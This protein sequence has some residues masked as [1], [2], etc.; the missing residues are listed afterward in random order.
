V[1]GAIWTR[2]PTLIFHLSRPKALVHQIDP[3]AM[4]EGPSH[5]GVRKLRLACKKPA[6]ESASPI[7]NFSVCD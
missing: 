2:K 3:R 7:S 4:F 6:F 5:R 1:T